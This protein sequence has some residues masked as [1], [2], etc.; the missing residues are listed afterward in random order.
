MDLFESNFE[1]TCAMCGTELGFRRYKARIGSQYRFCTIQHLNS[2]I[3]QR[4]AAVRARDEVQ[5]AKD[6]QLRL[7]RSSD[8]Q[9]PD[10]AADT[11][12]PL[13]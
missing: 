12:Y 9:Q 8:A 11:T 7:L 10:I 2:W 6:S 13:L 3:T 5:A 1:R 4:E